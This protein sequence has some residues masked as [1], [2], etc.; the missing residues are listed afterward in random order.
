MK[1]W[2][3][4]KTTLRT[5]THLVVVMYWLQVRMNIKHIGSIFVVNKVMPNSWF[6]VVETWI[7]QLRF[8]KKATKLTKSPSWFDVNYIN[9]KS[10]GRFRQSFVAFLKKHELYW[11]QHLAYFLLGESHL[12]FCFFMSKICTKFF[13]QFVFLMKM[14]NFCSSSKVPAIILQCNIPSSADNFEESS[15][16]ELF[17]VYILAY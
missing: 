14:N 17:F 1:R 2:Q 3:R 10:T 16:Q 13:S 7:L 4:Q 6:E 8:S 15:E 12:N 5:A 11:S 9:F